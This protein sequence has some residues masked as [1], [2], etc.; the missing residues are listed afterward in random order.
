MVVGL[1]LVVL[2]GVGAFSTPTTE[3]RR[4]VARLGKPLGIPALLLGLVIV[5]LG[6]DL[7]TR[8]VSRCSVRP[9]SSASLNVRSPAEGQRFDTNAVPV[10]VELSGGTLAPANVDRLQPGRGHLQISV[11]RN[12]V[13]RAANVVQVIRVANGPHRISV[14]YVAADHLPFCPKI[15]VTRNVRVSA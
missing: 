6:E 13:S 2:G 5:F 15:G 9:S 8:Y 10:R 4:G 3:P 1:V 11:D 7:L 12:V 14:E